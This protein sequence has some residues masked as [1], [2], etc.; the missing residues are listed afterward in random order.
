MRNSA[1]TYPY[2]LVFTNDFD[3]EFEMCVTIEYD[4][5]PRLITD[6]FLELTEEADLKAEAAQ[7]D[8]TEY[9]LEKILMGG[10]VVA[11]FN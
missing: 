1:I 3:R 10:A 4:K 8:L 2:T 7:V 11:K 9:T 6:D 5:P